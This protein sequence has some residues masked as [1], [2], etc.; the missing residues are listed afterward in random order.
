M[1]I[2]SRSRVLDNRFQCSYVCK[3]Y[4]GCTIYDICLCFC[5]TSIKLKFEKRNCLPQ[6][7]LYLFSGTHLLVSISIQEVAQKSSIKNRSLLVTRR[8][9]SDT[10]LFQGSSSKTFSNIRNDLTNFGKAY[11]RPKLKSWW[12]LPISNH[13]RPNQNGW[14]STATIQ[15]IR[16]FKLV[17]QRW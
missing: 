5:I 10:S 13:A 11:R 3:V 6:P 1:S 7:N 12:F 4:L 15:C 16:D 2:S 8:P 14:Q 9:L 17:C